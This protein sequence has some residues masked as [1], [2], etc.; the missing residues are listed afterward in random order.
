MRNP[1]VGIPL[2]SVVHQTVCQYIA[3]KYPDVMFN[4]DGAGNYLS[5]TQAGMNKMLRSGAGFPDLQLLVPKGRYFGMFLELKR[6]NATVYLK[7]GNLSTNSHIQEQAGVLNRLIALGYYANFAVGADD[8]MR[9]IDHYMGL[10]PLD[11]QAWLALLT[12]RPSL[13]QP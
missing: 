8:A 2:E 7:N 4:S 5:P 1:N 6:E 3:Y 9:Q 12:N 11:P 13:S 10:K